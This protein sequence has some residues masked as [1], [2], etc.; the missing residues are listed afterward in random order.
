MAKLGVVALGPRPC[1][2]RAK[3]Q[4]AH[5]LQPDNDGV[6]WHMI[7]VWAIDSLL[8]TMGC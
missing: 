5:L 8:F 6:G 1:P 3:R 4:H 2:F 7:Q